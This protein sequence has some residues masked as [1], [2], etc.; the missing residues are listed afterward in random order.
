MTQEQ[1]A[2]IMDCHI[3]SYYLYETGRVEMPVSKA[4]KL[5]EYFDIDWWILYEE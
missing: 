4:K 5:A 1:F 3:N 2:N